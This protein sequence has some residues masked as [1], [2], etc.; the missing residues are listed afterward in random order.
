M[1][2]LAAWASPIYRQTVW[3]VVGSLAFFGILVYFFRNKSHY[4]KVSWASIKSW[5]IAAPILL[6]ILGAPEPFPL[7][8]ITILA[9]TGAKVFFQ[10]LG[11]FH[12][13]WFVFSC[14]LGIL[15]LAFS[16]HYD[17]LDWY[18][19]MPMIV[20]GL[21]CL[22]PLLRNNFKNMIQ[23]ISLTLLAFIFMGWSFM[24]LGL[25]LEMPKGVYQLIYLIILTEFCDNTIL[26]TSRYIGR[27]KI[28]DRINPK[29]TFESAAFSVLLTIG[30]AFIMRYLLPDDAEDYWLISGLIAGFGGF[31]GDLVMTVIR[32][33]LGIRDYGVFIIGRGDFLQRM[34]RLIFV[35]PIY[36]Y[37]VLAFG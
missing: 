25:I 33:D 37:L 1:S 2:E 13:T 8:M 22:I 18:N 26:A 36:Y 4:F 3:T 10:I 6:G 20:L 29:R 34:D 32:K 31:A 12:R 27:F 30:L 28:A 21:V 7:I 17:R 11:M 9:L 16:V 14:Y 5:L 24:H 15:F 35:A 19:L 23:Y